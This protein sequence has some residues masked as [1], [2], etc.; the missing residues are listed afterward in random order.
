MTRAEIH[1]QFLHVRSAGYASHLRTNR[2]IID[3]PREIRWINITNEPYYILL[4]LRQNKII[5]VYNRFR[6]S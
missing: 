1:K 2:C 4:T 6:T 5:L 3:A